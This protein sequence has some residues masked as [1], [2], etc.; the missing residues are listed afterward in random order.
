MNSDFICISRIE[1][2]S[3]MMQ[4]ST[5]YANF[6]FVHVGGFFLN[7]KENSTENRRTKIFE[8]SSRAP[9]SSYTSLSFKKNLWCLENTKINKS[10]YII[11]AIFFL[12]IF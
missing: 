12:L 10:H 3:K 7:I 2:C 4:C 6:S 8:V 5:N 1:K 11:F 9:C